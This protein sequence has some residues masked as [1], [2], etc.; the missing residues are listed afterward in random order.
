MKYSREMLDLG[1]MESGMNRKLINENSE[2][3]FLIVDCFD[4][5]NQQ[6][7][8]KFFEKIIKQCNV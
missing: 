2:H 5:H 3:E 1:E 8:E 6:E 7:R 4:I